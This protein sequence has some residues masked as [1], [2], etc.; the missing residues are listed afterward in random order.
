LRNIHKGETVRI[1]VNALQLTARN[2]GV[3]Q[4]IYQMVSSL[5]SSG[6]DQFQI[7]SSNGMAPAEWSSRRNV[8]IKEIPFRKEQLI[9]RN[10]YELFFFG[11]ALGRD[12][13]SL[14]WSP[15][16]KLPIFLPSDIPYVV[17]VHDLA[18]LREPETY[19]LS[20]VVYWRK[21]F[22]HAIQRSALVVADSN[23]TRDDLM[24]LMDVPPE[25]IRVIYCGVSP[26]F[27][28][29]DDQDYLARVARKYSLPKQFLL[30]VGLFSPR[31]N[32]A[33]ILQAYAILKKKHQ[34]SHHLVMVGERGWRY[35]ADLELVQRLGLE[36]DV[37]FPGF[38]EDED[39]PAV[40]NL[41]DVFIFPSLYEGFGLPVLE[42][43]ACG[44]PVVTSDLSAL[45]EVVGD[46]GV[47][48]DPRDPEEIASGV[49]RLLSNSKLASGLARAGLE[50]SSHF[51]WTNAA[52]ELMAVFQELT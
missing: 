15:D 11:A 17:T 47:L 7:Y 22:K 29:I 30:F 3:G 50:R 28:L 23:A 45:P 31:K 20:R 19:K 43:M 44:T 51:T 42:A 38:V 16:T 12:K 32:I 40:Y 48:I 39:L 5:L 46:A 14:F 35:R 24:E 52:R 21:L 41:A 8:D 37:V 6:T 33:G 2:S 1:G 34:V 26:R 36:S 13:L 18:I 27:R 25:K 10:L 4:Y 9:L 49:Y